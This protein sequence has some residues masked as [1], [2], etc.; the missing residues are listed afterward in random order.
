VR[1]EGLDQSS[2][3][4]D[5]EPLCCETVSL[6]REMF[7]AMFGNIGSRSVNIACV[8]HTAA[9]VMPTSPVPAPISRT[10]IT[11]CSDG[12]AVAFPG[13]ETGPVKSKFSLCKVLARTSEDPHVAS[14]RL[15]AVIFD[16]SEMVRAMV[17]PEGEVWMGNW[18]RVRELI[19]EVSEDLMEYCEMGT[20][21][22]RE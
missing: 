20:F 16:G 3:P 21:L 4:Q 15:S 2:S 10:G 14:A 22:L 9:A 19:L 8:C 11:W 6:F 12:V 17:S 5:R 18:R 13:P 1:E 7:A